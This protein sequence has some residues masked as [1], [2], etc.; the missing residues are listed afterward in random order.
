MANRWKGNFV[1][2]AATTSSGANYIGKADGAWSLNNQ[3]QQ[4]QANLWS[5][6]IG[7]PTAPTIGAAVGG[8]ASATVNFTASSDIGAPSVTYTATSTPEGI[9]ATGTSGPILMSGLT[10]NVSY[11]FKVKAT[12]SVNLV[13]SESAASN[14]VTPVG[15]SLVS[16]AVTGA[17]NCFETY[18][19]TGGLVTK[20]ANPATPLNDAMSL[21]FKG[22]GSVL[23][24]GKAAIPNAYA[25]SG[26]SYGTKYAAPATTFGGGIFGQQFSPDGTLVVYAAFSAP[27]I[28]LYPWNNTNGF[29]TKYANP[30]TAVNGVGE[31]VSFY[32]DGTVILVKN[33]STPFVTAYAVSSS[34]FGTKFADPSSL[35]TF[36]YMTGKTISVK[37]G[38]VAFTCNVSPSIHAYAWS[39]GFGTKYANPSSLP[40]GPQGLGVSFSSSGNSL[41][42]ATKNSPYIAGYNWS[43]ASGFGTRYANPANALPAE[44]TDIAFMANNSAI[45]VG[46]TTS[47]FVTAYNWSDSGFGS[48]ISNNGNSLAARPAYIAT[49]N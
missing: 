38:A 31:G 28:N 6:S 23:S 42:V 29:G 18:T 14:S 2:A 27:S 37:T 44:T 21:C 25:I 13:S 19:W 5:K 30:S 7:T 33:D 22:D 24:V 10:N 49:N 26:G 15:V 9:T 1:I 48:V 40:T 45:I 12:N 39:N 16:F 4:K 3:L 36:S 35:A 43:N 46:G 11:T 8:N 17:S 32:P 34:G 41:V 47:P 20:F